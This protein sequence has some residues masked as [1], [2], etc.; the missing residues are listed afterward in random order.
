MTVSVLGGNANGA[1]ENF[2]CLTETTLLPEYKTEID[3]AWRIL[4]VG[5]HH[6][7]IKALCLSVSACP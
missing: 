5:F 2:A 3:E 1:F 6:L 4:R 7:A